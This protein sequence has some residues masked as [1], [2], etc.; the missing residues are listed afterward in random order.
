[1][2]T[3]LLCTPLIPNV[4][5]A[6]QSLRKSHF[7]RYFVAPSSAPSS[8]GDGITTALTRESQRQE[9]H[10][11]WRDNALIPAVPP[12]RGDGFQRLPLTSCHTGHAEIPPN[13]TAT[14]HGAGA[15]LPDLFT[16]QESCLKVP[17]LYSAVFPSLSTSSSW[18]SQS[19]PQHTNN[20]LAQ[21]LHPEGAKLTP[22]TE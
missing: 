12:G 7:W 9:L 6:P 16:A 1:M 14:P 10:S 4:A 18:V 13:P 3:L 20:L 21:I 8:L 17:G 5:P 15:A 19:P 11:A 2:S 22:G